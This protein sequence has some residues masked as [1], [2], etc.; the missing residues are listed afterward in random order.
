MTAKLYTQQQ[1]TRVFLGERREVVDPSKVRNP[2]VVDRAVGCDLG[3]GEEALRHDIGGAGLAWQRASEIA[4]S[5]FSVASQCSAWAVPSPPCNRC[6]LLVL[7]LLDLHWRQLGFT[8]RI[9]T[10]K[11]EKDV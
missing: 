9:L 11:T 3:W 1:L 8:P 7:L 5:A 10:A 2:E 6:W 4:T